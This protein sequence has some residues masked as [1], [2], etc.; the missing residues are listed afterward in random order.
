MVSAER[1]LTSGECGAVSANAL[2]TPR[3]KLPLRGAPTFL[4]GGFLLGDATVLE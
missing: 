3:L 1:A 4:Q 2:P